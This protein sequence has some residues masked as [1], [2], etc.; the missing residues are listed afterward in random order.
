MEEEGVDLAC[1]CAM[2]PLRT[3]TRGPAPACVGDT[4]VIDE[5]L[6]YFR[7]NVLFRNFEVYG[8]ADRT[9]IYL[10]LYIGLCL[11]ACERIETREEAKAALFQLAIKPFAVPGDS[12]WTLGAMFPTPGSRKDGDS[13]RAYFKQ[14]RTELSERVVD[15]LFN[16][17]GSKNKWWNS[18]IKRKFMG[19]ELRA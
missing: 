8:S 17:D 11:K 12:G 5:A 9:L 6:N 7:A 10:T 2:L 1:G 18:F 13:F 19:K 4:D 14:A 16:D 15:K 3:S